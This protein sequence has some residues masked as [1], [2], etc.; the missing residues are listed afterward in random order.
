MTPTGQL[1]VRP[2]RAMKEEEE[3]E[4]GSSA[5][6]VPAREARRGTSAIPFPPGRGTRGNQ[7]QFRS[8]PRGGQGGTSVISLPPTDNRSQPSPALPC[9]APIQP[10]AGA[11]TR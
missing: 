2:E 6:P 9:P 7:R 11:S 5:S 8:R 1:Q 10:S 4:E 3:E